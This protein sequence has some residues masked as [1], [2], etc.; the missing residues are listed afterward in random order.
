[1]YTAQVIT[2]SDRSFR[3]ERPDGSGPVVRQLL[4]EAGYQVGEVVIVPDEQPLIEE[5]L[6]NAAGED[7]ALIVTTGGTGFAPRDVTPEAT[8]AVCQ[9]L[10]PGIPEAMRA[11]SMAITPRGCLSR[12]SAGIR[13]RSL[14]INLPGSPKAARENLEA[15][16]DPIGHGLQMLRGG[17]AD[18]AALL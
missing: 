7:I 11:A 6:I 16:L 17:Q 18:C 12:A 9:R 1:M 3:G 15:V 4:E 8:L 10:T 5:A 13:N 14:I 2:V